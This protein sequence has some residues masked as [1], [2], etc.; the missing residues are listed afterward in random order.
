M[1]STRAG[2]WARSVVS[3]APVVGL[4]PRPESRPNGISAI[5]RVRGEETWLEPALLSIADFADEIIVLDNGAAPAS[6]GAVRAVR[7]RLGARLTVEACPDLDLF[8]LSNRGLDVSH[9]RW[10]IRWDADFV[11][12]TDGDG[13]IRRL[14]EFLLALDPRR[15]HVV[16]LPAAEVAGDL[17]HQFPERRVR[18]D[19]AAHTASARA[20][21]VYVRRDLPLGSV[22]FPDRLFH[23]G[24]TLPVSFESIQLPRYYRVHTWHAI[25]YLHVDVKPRRHLLLRHF[26]LEWL[27]EASDPRYPTLEAYARARVAARMGVADL[28]QAADVLLTRYCEGLAPYDAARCGPLPAALR[29]YLDASPYRLQHAGDRIVGR[30]EPMSGPR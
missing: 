14:R 17:S 18:V 4:A 27:R 12:H 3:L 15:Y 5:V 2:S 28:D 19:G 24:P 29:P 11:A 6:A 10:V 13:D 21:Y 9:R 30:T 23:R 22:A 8:A 7:E 25:S 20:R 16:Y 1:L 26:W